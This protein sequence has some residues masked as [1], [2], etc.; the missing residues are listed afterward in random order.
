MKNLPYPKGTRVWVPDVPAHLKSCLTVQLPKSQVTIPDLEAYMELLARKIQF[1]INLEADHKAALQ[2]LLQRLNPVLNP[3]S[4]EQL[5]K[6]PKQ[7]GTM[8]VQALL[9]V[10]LSQIPGSEFPARSLPPQESRP[11]LERMEH[12][13]V[14]AEWVAEMEPDDSLR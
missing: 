14:L 4:Q 13:E 3:V 11:R 7:A 6:S 10:L 1:L 12:E 2:D 8:I 9:P 5:L